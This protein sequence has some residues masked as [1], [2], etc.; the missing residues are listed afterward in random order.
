MRKV[1]EGKVPSET[2]GGVAEANGE[3]RGKE[4]RTEISWL[5]N[6][7]KKIGS[8]LKGLEFERARGK[9]ASCPPAHRSKPGEGLA[10]G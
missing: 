1:G 10:D 3:T 7:P 6:G 9:V 8:R 4:Q 2:P 5:Q